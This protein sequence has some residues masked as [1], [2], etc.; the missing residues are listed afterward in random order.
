MNR[1]DTVVALFALGAAGVPFGSLAQQKDRLWRVGMVWGGTK[2]TVKANEAAFL[3]GMK[4]L[5]YEVGRNLIVDMRYAGG[6]PA[7]YPALVDEVI[8]LKPD[9]LMGT[10]TGVAIE[11]KR[12]TATLPIVTGTTA[13]PVGIGL[14]QSLARPGG[15]VTGMAMQ[16][17]ELSAKQIEIMADVLPRMRRVA[18]LF[19]QSQA[20]ITGNQ[21]EQIAKTAA[22]AKGLSLD[23]HR[24]AGPEDIRQAFR[25]LEARRADALLIGP[26]PP[27]NAQRKEIC[28]SAASI[29]LPSIGFSDDWAHDGALMS[30]GPSFVEANRRTAYFVDR[31]FK[32]A[33]P[34][35]LPIEQPTKFSLVINATTAKTLG[36]TI[37][38]IVLLRADEVIE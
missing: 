18:L 34:G 25:K 22:A 17:G 2:F 6:D 29:R 31:I 8:T 30:F 36:I 10:N 3:A 20:K 24:V 33:K 35:D 7:R 23:V 4:D 28:R 15:N 19:D 14:A 21:Y 13:D 12:R 27:F 9:V 5:G 26:S 11:M 38:Q 1:R 37:P 16:L 32:G